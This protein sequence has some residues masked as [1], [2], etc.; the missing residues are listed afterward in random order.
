MSDSMMAPCGLA[1]DECPAYIAKRI[2][3]DALRARTAKRWS[4]PGFQVY[5][6]DVSCDGCSTA[7]GERFVHC[8]TCEVRRCAM[9]RAIVTCAE[10]SDY[11][12]GKLER[13]LRRIGPSART[14]LER[15]RSERS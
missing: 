11:G 6:E 14:T 9:L 1:C 12:C 4:E 8:A 3:D 7:G 2:G 10:C 13:L 5:A 15:L